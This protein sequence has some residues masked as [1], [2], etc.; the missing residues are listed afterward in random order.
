MKKEKRK[1][2]E[3][4][5]RTVPP[6]SGTAVHLEPPTHAKTHD[7]TLF[8]FAVAA[9]VAFNVAAPICTKSPVEGS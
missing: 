4:F 9:K 8:G 5:S 1:K 2:R 7:D 3:A 6:A